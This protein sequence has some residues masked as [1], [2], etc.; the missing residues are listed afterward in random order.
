LV[1]NLAVVGL[2]VA[3]LLVALGYWLYRRSTT[4]WELMAGAEEEPEATAKVA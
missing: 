2:V 1:Q 3:A 4:R